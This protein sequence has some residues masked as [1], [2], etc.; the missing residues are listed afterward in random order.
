MYNRKRNFPATAHLAPIWSTC[1]V[2]VLLTATGACIAA[3]GTAM[4][5]HS[6]LQGMAK[7]EESITHAQSLLPEIGK[8]AEG[9]AR[10]WTAGGD[11]YAAGDSC[12]TDELFYRSGG[13]IGLKRIGPYKQNG[14]GSQVTWGKVPEKSVI[15]YVMHRNADPGILLFEDLGHLMAEGNTVVFFGSSRWP[16]CRRAVDAL[17]KRVPAERCFFIDTELPMDTSFTTADGRHY[18]DFAGMV[19]TVHAWTFTAELI[20]A[21]T[22]Q[23]KMP[24]IWPSGA[25]PGY[26]AWEKQYGTNAFHADLTLHPIEAGVLGRRYLQS[27]RQQIQACGK[28]TAQVRAAARMLADVPADRAVYAM[29]DSHLLAGETWLPKA[30]P[31]WML[32]QRRWRW[33]RAAPTI[34]RGDGVFWMGEYNWPTTEV[35]QAV[36]MGNPM[37]VASLYGPGQPPG[38]TPLVTPPGTPPATEPARISVELSPPAVAT[39][40]PTNV[41]WIPVSWQ[42]PDAV[43]E[44]DGYPLP[45]CPSSSI[46]QGLL[47]WGVIGEVLENTPP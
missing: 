43:V 18:G 14:N 33:R 19:T 13:L 26:E 6:L 31:N 8:A 38:H 41:V 27:L 5:S 22:R 40:G 4:A 37:A 12:A 2:A 3:T 36:K 25:I 20:A 17:R 44:L 29:V 23:N 35:E 9:V 11:L 10:R 47:L 15:L 24:I 32:V 45:V 21:C 7:M 42:Y 16:A 39:P 1:I 46:V 34:E 30:L 28:S